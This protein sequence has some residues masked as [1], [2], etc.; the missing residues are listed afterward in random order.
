MRKERKAKSLDPAMPEIR[1]SR[2]L[3]HTSNKRPFCLQYFEITVINLYP[4]RPD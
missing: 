1:D 3:K 4:R 2:T